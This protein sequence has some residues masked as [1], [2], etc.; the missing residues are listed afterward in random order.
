[1]INNQTTLDIT[2]VT[3]SQ[4]LDEFVVVGYGEQKKATMTGA[5][6]SVG[7]K[8]LIQSPVSN[9][10]NSLVGRLPGLIAVQSSGEPGYDQS[11]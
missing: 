7:T 4:A 9:I 8:E 2:M 10:S 1:P 11:S 5:V 6:S 3:D